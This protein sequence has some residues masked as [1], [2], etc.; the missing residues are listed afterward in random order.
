MSLI[1]LPSPADDYAAPQGMR[2]NPAA[3]NAALVSVGVR[4]RAIEAQ[5]TDLQALIDA[6][7]DQALAVIQANVAPQL[8]AINATIDVAAD[9]LAALQDQI[10]TLTGGGGGSISPLLIVQDATHR[11]ITD[12]ILTDLQA[13]VT[14]AQLTSAVN[15]LVNAAP[16]TLDT[17]KELADALGSDPN[18][19]STMTAALAKRLRFDA[20]QVLSAGEKL[21]AKANLGAITSSDVDSSVWSSASSAVSLGAAGYQKLPS[22]LIVQWGLIPIAQQSVSTHI[23]STT[24]PLAF[25][26]AAYQVFP[27]GMRDHAGPADPC[28][29]GQPDITSLTT[30][31]VSV[32][33]VNIPSTSAMTANLSYIAVGR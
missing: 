33:V 9:D 25:P 21:Q 31:G 24:F 11:F 8:A 29:F 27:V 10:A 28:A 30:T 14:S 17:L 26:N 20:A 16:G 32:R 3:W 2:L 4:L 12:A 19:A 1:P 18:F 13:R 15:G 23:G 7:T 6:G 22:G 5:R